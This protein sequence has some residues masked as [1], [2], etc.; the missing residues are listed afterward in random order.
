M[1]PHRPERLVDPHRFPGDALAFELVPAS[2]PGV[3]EPLAADHVSHDQ[4]RKH[5]SLFPEE[6][7]DNEV[8]D[9]EDEPGVAVL[10]PEVEEGVDDAPP[11]P[12]VVLRVPG[13]GHG[14]SVHGVCHEYLGL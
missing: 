8:G 12:G 5:L 3:G 6:I 13:G 1:E 10:R 9:V 2:P 7:A 4:S 14:P 11:R